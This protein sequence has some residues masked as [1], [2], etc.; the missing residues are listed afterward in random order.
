MRLREQPSKEIEMY[1]H[2]GLYRS[3]DGII[4]GV[5]TGIARYFDLSVFWTRIATLLML[6]CTGFW[7]VGFLYV[8]AALLMK[9]EPLLSFVHEHEW[10][11]I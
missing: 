9:K 2:S 7:P 6:F 8:F 11:Q 3:R 5:C 4:F 10:G 1:R